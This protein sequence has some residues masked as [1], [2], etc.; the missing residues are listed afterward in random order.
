MIEIES[1][2]PQLSQLYGGKIDFHDSEWLSCDATIERDTIGLVVLWV[3]S[4]P[5]ATN[6]GLVVCTVEFEGV[7]EFSAPNRSGD[8]YGMKFEEFESGLYRLRLTDSWRAC[9]TEI[10]FQSIQ[11]LQVRVISMDLFKQLQSDNVNGGRL[12]VRV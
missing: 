6:T 7:T 5:E 3:F 1:F 12:T 8:F 2:F 4:E 9:P 11:E 10:I